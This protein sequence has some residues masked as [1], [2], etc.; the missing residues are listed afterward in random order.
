MIPDE[1]SLYPQAVRGL[2][3]GD[4][5]LACSRGSPGV[6]VRLSWSVFDRSYV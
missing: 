4:T 2:F 1:L 6:E 3:E 5:E